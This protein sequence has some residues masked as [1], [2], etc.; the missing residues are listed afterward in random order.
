MALE[1]ELGAVPATPEEI[2]ALKAGTIPVQSEDAQ[3]AELGAV[4]ATPEE[5][6]RIKEAQAFDQPLLAGAAGVARGASLG[7]SDVLGSKIGLKEDLEKLKRYNPNASTVGDIV[8]TVGSTVTG[9]GLPGLVSKA[10]AK[11]GSKGLAALAAREAIEGAAI[12]AGQAI[13]NIAL[14][15]KQYTPQELA[16]NLI[17]NVGIG[18]LVGG[19]TSLALSGI[20][21]GSKKALNLLKRPE[22]T[23]ASETVQNKL[24]KEADNLTDQGPKKFDP[25]NYMAG[26][27]GQLKPN[28]DELM[29]AAKELDA[30]LTPGFLTSSEFGQNWETAL[31]YRPTLVGAEV[32]KARQQGIVEPVN[33]AARKLFRDAEKADQFEIGAQLKSELVETIGKRKDYFDEVYGALKLEQKAIPVAKEENK[34]LIKLVQRNRGIEAELSPEYARSVNTVKR[35]LETGKAKNVNDLVAISK[36]LG[37]EAFKAG[38]TTSRQLIYKLKD[39]VDR[40]IER[41]AMRAAVGI[42]KN[43]KEQLQAV[44]GFVKAKISVNKEYAQLKT[45]IEDLGEISKIRGKS[46]K[47]FME[48]IESVPNEKLGANFVKRNLQNSDGLK[49]LQDQFPKQFEL[50]QRSYLRTLFDKSVDNKGRFQLS[51]MLTQLKSVPKRTQEIIFGTQGVRDLNN[52]K[53]VLAAAPENFNPSG[54]AMGINFSEQSLFNILPNNLMDYAKFAYL[55]AS[56]KEPKIAHAVDNVLNRIGLMADPGV[57]EVIRTNDRLITKRINSFLDR[58]EKKISGAITGA[59]TVVGNREANERRI[60]DVQEIAMDP[61]VLVEKAMMNTAGIRE[62]SPETANEVVGTAVR[63]ADFLASKAPKFIE[64]DIFTEKND[65]ISDYETAKFNRYLK[66]VENPFTVLEDINAGKLTAQ[67]IEALKTVYPALYQQIND[68]VFEILGSKNNKLTYTQKTQLS[69]LLGIPVTSTMDPKFIAKMQ[70][71]A[72]VQT[73]QE[74]QQEQVQ[75]SQKVKPMKNPPRDL[76][77]NF[78][79][80]NSEY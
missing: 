35:V 41:S 52:I 49:L 70:N 20:G 60:K 23:I 62:Y 28:A 61:S 53:T 13:S 74:M 3:L 76:E 26:E 73:T 78:Q 25:E 2:A 39:Q 55:K 31:T 29:Q 22:K 19:G 21:A 30:E 43:K 44:R 8:G 71:R 65:Q 7:L 46:P 5:I 1:D 51:S 12:G 67:S 75:E 36:Q 33:K 11:I 56:V 54:T 63:A 37:D 16:E 27:I 69:L 6:A 64:R 14:N 10:A 38:P 47:Q 18:A 59:L 48:A 15:D 40:T 68:R 4:R 17:A 72:P 9:V 42:T 66:V 57:Q 77:T 24:L 58:N 79:R 50:M 32:R 34:R 80:V 45:L